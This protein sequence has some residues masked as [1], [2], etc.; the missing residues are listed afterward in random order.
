[1][2]LQNILKVKKSFFLSLFL[3]F[4]THSIVS[5]QSKN[6][7]GGGISVGNSKSI[8]AASSNVGFQPVDSNF[9]TF[10]A[11]TF[12]NLNSGQLFQLRVNARFNSKNIRLASDDLVDFGGIMINSLGY[13]FFSVDMGL[14][15]LYA[16]PLKESKLLPAFG[17]FSSYNIS[18]RGFNFARND[19]TL[20]PLELIE[21]FPEKTNKPMVAFFGFN[22]GLLYQTEIRGK[23]IEF[24]G[25]AYFSGSDSFEATYEYENIDDI[26]YKGHIRSIE[27]GINI[28]IFLRRN[29]VKNEG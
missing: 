24:Y 4:S 3:F 12:L 5:A 17:I 11:N 6:Y 7:I 9:G 20:S 8:A 19:G 15:G 28:P 14:T 25:M 1:M 27:F 10:C 16:I 22:T 23:P 18:T 13:Q 29:Q 26:S 2:T 21:G